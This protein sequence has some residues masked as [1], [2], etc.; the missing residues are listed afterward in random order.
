MGG[1]LH[2]LLVWTVPIT[3][4]YGAELQCAH[5]HWASRTTWDVRA[6]PE[7]RRTRTMQ[8]HTL[9]QGDGNTGLSLRPGLAN[10]C[11]ISFQVLRACAP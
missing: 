3:S 9:N 6:M 4:R 2:A 7:I 5:P 1:Y 8:P 11:L 10:V